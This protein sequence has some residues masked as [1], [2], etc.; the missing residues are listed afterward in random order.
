MVFV[1]KQMEM[2]FQ[3]LAFRKKSPSNGFL[4]LMLIKAT[5]TCRWTTNKSQAHTL[6][7]L[8]PGVFAVLLLNANPDDSPYYCLT[9]S[10]T[11]C[12]VTLLCILEERKLSGFI[13][14]AWN[15]GAS[16]YGGRKIDNNKGL[17]ISNA[18]NP[19]LLLY[20]SSFLFWE[21]KAHSGE[22][23]AVRYWNL[24][25]S[26]PLSLNANKS[27]FEKKKKEEIHTTGSLRHW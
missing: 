21:T 1:V 6:C 19:F 25:K 27:T 15:P 16:V 7:I 10:N 17:S 22:P 12:F 4:C 5:V 8:H 13:V 24:C 11:A 3:W 23:N 9:G 18:Y 26:L 14:F 2:R 20:F